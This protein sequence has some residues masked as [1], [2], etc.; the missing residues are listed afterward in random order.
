MLWQLLP[1]KHRV[2]QQLL[3]EARPEAA[4]S[5]GK[6]AAVLLI[7][8][9]VLE[10]DVLNDTGRIVGSP[11]LVANHVRHSSTHGHTA[12][13]SLSGGSNLARDKITASLMRGKA[14]HATEVLPGQLAEVA[15]A[16]C[17]TVPGSRSS[18]LGLGDPNHFGVLNCLMRRCS[19]RRCGEFPLLIARHLCM[20]KGEGFNLLV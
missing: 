9:Q 14:G 13:R 19:M 20:L 5:P 16:Q 18:N 10:L 1:Q 17:I 11:V 6:I 2:L 7:S 3:S 12:F 8:R 15:V 4:K